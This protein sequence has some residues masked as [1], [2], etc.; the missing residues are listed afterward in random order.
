[1]CF[2]KSLFC[3]SSCISLLL[4]INGQPSRSTEGCESVFLC[5][6]VYFYFAD[7]FFFSFSV[8]SRL[9]LTAAAT[10]TTIILTTRLKTTTMSKITREICASLPDADNRS[11]ASSSL[12]WILYEALDLSLKRVSLKSSFGLHRVFSYR[13]WLG[14]LLCLT[15]DHRRIC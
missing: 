15:A 3:L 9:E 2:A 14:F 6:P 10:V 8:R 1:M 13:I 11:S 7:L 12:L 4:L 5:F